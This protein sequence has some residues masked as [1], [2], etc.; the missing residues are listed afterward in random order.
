M[1]QTK[2]LPLITA[3]DS[4]HTCNYRPGGHRWIDDAQEVGAH[5]RTGTH[6]HVVSLTRVSVLRVVLRRDLMLTTVVAVFAI[7][8]VLQLVWL[9]REYRQRSALLQFS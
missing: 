9:V 6:S 2:G 1:Q 8:T 4:C 7:V 3:G 5:R